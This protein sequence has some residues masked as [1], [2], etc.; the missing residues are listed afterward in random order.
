MKKHVKIISIMVLM[1]SAKFAYSQTVAL[2]TPSDVTRTVN[3]SVSVA[4]KA[5]L[6]VLS[7]S[8]ILN[9]GNE[10]KARGYVD[11]P[12]AIVLKVWCNSIDG[13]RVMGQI[14][15]Q[16]NE[17]KGKIL[18]RLSGEK[19]FCEATGSL[20]DIYESYKIERGSKVS[21]DIRYLLSDNTPAGDH[22]F[23]ASF[24]AEPK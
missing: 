19:N 24:V 7:A 23:E 2:L 15:P 22:Q 5:R 8:N 4:K 9:V 6:E 17:I 3:V 11:L 13:A 10:D 14:E 18:Y 20:H 21:L 1:I 12:K 16:N